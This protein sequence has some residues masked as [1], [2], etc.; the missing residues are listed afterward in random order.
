MATEKRKDTEPSLN[1]SA[2][3]RYQKVSEWG[4]ALC[5]AEYSSLLT[6]TPA[7]D[8]PGF[9]SAT[10]SDVSLPAFPP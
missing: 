8:A 2:A 4:A 7:I 3:V 1:Q 9:L 10:L 5:T 6:V